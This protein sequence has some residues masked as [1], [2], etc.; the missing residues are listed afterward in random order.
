[1]KRRAR[2]VVLGAAALVAVLVAVVVVT[3]RGT[4][5]DHVEAWHFQATTETETITPPDDRERD[6]LERWYFN[7]HM[8]S[9]MTKHSPL[10]FHFQLLAAAFRHPVILDKRVGWTT[11][12]DGMAHGGAAP[13]LSFLRERG[14]RVLE[15][16]FP[17]R[18]FVVISAPRLTEDEDTYRLLED[19]I[20]EGESETERP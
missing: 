11:T 5:R 10:R 2:P 14:Y 3:H 9:E 18:A 1:M 17:R 19:I 15:Q 20:K 8:T 16:R 6:A 13:M 12:V 7:N 4:V